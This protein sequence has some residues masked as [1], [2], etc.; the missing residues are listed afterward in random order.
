M[1][2]G[3]ER[4]DGGAGNGVAV[5][6][7]LH[8]TFF[9]NLLLVRRVKETSLLCAATSRIKYG[10]RQQW[11]TNYITTILIIKTANWVGFKRSWASANDG[12]VEYCEVKTSLDGVVPGLLGVT[13]PLLGTF[14]VFEDAWCGCVA[15]DWYAARP[16][17]VCGSALLSNERKHEEE[18]GVMVVCLAAGGRKGSVERTHARWA[19]ED[20]ECCLARGEGYWGGE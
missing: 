2:T 16:K 8:L 18:T 3:L 6:C 9:V 14:W 17:G 20:G 5:N 10:Y 12:E 11:R 7:T 15:R 19:I 13:R 1:S 4:T